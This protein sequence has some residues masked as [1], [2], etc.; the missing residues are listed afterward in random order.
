MYVHVMFMST[1]P[2]HACTDPS[3]PAALADGIGD[4]DVARY[5]AVLHELL[6]I[7]TAIARTVHREMLAE[8]ASWRPGKPAGRN[9]VAAF[10]VISRAI[11]R[12]IMLSMKLAELRAAARAVPERK[13]APVLRVVADEA[14]EAARPRAE[15]RERLDRPDWNERLED[16]PVGEIIDGIRRDLGLAPVAQPLAL[17]L[18]TP[19]EVAA[20]RAR[21]A[22]AREQAPTL[23]HAPVF[24]AAAEASDGRMMTEVAGYRLRD[25]ADG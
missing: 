11:R 1:S 18:C 21:A 4:A 24:A 16:R 5:L 25:A 8:A 20:L 15:T 9:Y 3:Q 6:D 7:G 2:A 14:G 12:T 22:A 23:A 10:D 17:M 13:A 19:N